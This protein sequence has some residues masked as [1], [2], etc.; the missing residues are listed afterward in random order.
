MQDIEELHKDGGLSNMRGY[1]APSQRCVAD[2]IESFH[3][4][5]KVAQARPI[6][7]LTCEF[8][9]AQIHRQH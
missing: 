1:E 6:G 9:E 5:E 8:G 4:P 7:A 3:N 2:F